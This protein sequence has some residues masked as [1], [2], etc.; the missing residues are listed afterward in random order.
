MIKIEIGKSI[1]AMGNQSLFITFPYSETILDKVRTIPDRI[2]HPDLK[3]W[4]VSALLLEKVRHIFK[5]EHYAIYGNLEE[6]K[7]I[8]YNY[9]FKT[10]PMQH[11]LIAYQYGLKN[12]AFLLGDVMGLGKTKESLDL[13]CILKKNKGI[14]RVLIICGVNNLKYNWVEEIHKHTN[15]DCWIL[16]NRK[17]KNGKY[18]IG[19]TEDKIED[20][21]NLKS[22]DCFFLITNIESFRNSNFALEAQRQCDAKKIDM[23]IYDEAHTMKNPDAAQTKGVINLK[24]EYMVAMSGTFMLNRPLDLYSSLYW[25]GQYKKSYWVFKNT[26]SITDSWGNIVGV[27]NVD[28]LK[29]LI[30]NC[31]LRRLK[32]DVI[33]LPE[34][35]YIEEKVE[36]NEEQEQI[37]NEVMTHL[38][39]NIDKI[40]LSKNPLNEM[41]RARQATGCTSILSS[42]INESAKLDRLEELLDEITANGYKCLVF[43]NWVQMVNCALPR[44]KKY[45]PAVIT[46]EYKEDFIEAQKNKFHN[47][48]SCKVAIGTIGKMGTGL[49][50]NEANYVIF[51]DSPWTKGVKEQAVDRCHRIGQTKNV[52]IITLVAK[53]T[54]DEK[55]EQIVEEK[56]LMSDMLIDGKTNN[57]RIVDYL[58]S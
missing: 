30:S 17:L 39:Q 4:E 55:I 23:I 34:K 57:H 41:L 46:G 11:Q 27:K 33:N 25:I 58:L 16:G 18:R 15:E 9:T 3:C 6:E 12:K 47:D 29:K 52:T 42:S 19:K 1:K 13:A 26:F 28:L 20:L 43:S 44:I 38:R 21:R 8:D 54:I 56:G 10:Q 53:D 31:M 2:Y 48:S 7:E 51:L 49:T 40:R 37:Y 22:D 24:A 45:N 35:I 5:D 14:K 50:F 32:E 36:M